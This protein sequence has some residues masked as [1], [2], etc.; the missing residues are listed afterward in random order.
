MS[1]L[2]HRLRIASP[3]G[4]FCVGVRPLR[5]NKGRACFENTVFNYFLNVLRREKS[6][7]GITLGR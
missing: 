6:K 7:N 4:P 5:D 2:T 3:V 1:Y